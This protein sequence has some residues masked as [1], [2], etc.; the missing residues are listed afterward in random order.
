MSCEDPAAPWLGG[1]HRTTGST[2]HI[3]QGAKTPR[4]PP[5]LT[6]LCSCHIALLHRLI[7]DESESGFPRG[8]P[9]R[10]AGKIRNSRS[11][12]RHAR[13]MRTRHRCGS[14]AGD[15]RDGYPYGGCRCCWRWSGASAAWWP[16]PKTPGVFTAIAG[17]TNVGGYVDRR[18]F[19]R[20][21]P[22]YQAAIT[23]AIRTPGSRIL[24]G[25][26]GQN[27]Q[28][29]RQH[30]REQSQEG[31]KKGLHRTDSASAR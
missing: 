5:T 21:Q 13:A 10:C 7:H 16:Y 4:M 8:V 24:V 22:R 28:D 30:R 26:R 3:P 14:N 15:R 11:K 25:A 18:P 27:Q 19:S 1:G 6:L 12:L 31:A 20:R 29:R 17:T 2:K 9:A 23:D